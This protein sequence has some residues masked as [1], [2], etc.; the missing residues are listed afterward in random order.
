MKS[1]INNKNLSSL[2]IFLDT[3]DEM[4][5]DG[6]GDYFEELFWKLPEQCIW[7]ERKGMGVGHSFTS[8]DIRYC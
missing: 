7:N 2:I 6:S 3:P 1:I 5:E 4:V 8:C